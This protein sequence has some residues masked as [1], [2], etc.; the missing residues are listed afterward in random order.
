MFDLDF[1]CTTF[2]G[3]TL[4]VCSREACVACERL[5]VHGWLEMVSSCAVDEF[6]A[7]FALLGGLAVLS[8]R[9]R[10]MTARRCDRGKRFE[11]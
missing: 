3:V 4:R 1:R 8:T 7:R 6:F 10:L 5:G 11:S 2:F 9:R